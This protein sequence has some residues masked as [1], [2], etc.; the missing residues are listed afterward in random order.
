[1]EGGGKVKKPYTINALWGIW[2]PDGGRDNAG[3]WMLHAQRGDGPEVY[4]S[5]ED[6]ASA[7]D[8]YDKG[9]DHPGCYAAPITD[10]AKEK[11]P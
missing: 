3:S 8:S 9:G 7:A 2:L 1:M 11:M 5:M 6:A 4:E 10:A